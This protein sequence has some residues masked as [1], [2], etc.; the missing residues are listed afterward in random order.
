M[1]YTQAPSEKEQTFRDTRAWHG[2]GRAASGCHTPNA[3]SEPDHNRKR[4][5][6]AG[7]SGGVALSPGRRAAPEVGP[8]REAA[9]HMV[10]SW[11]GTRDRMDIGEAALDDVSPGLPASLDASLQEA[12]TGAAIS[13]YKDLA[14]FVLGGILLVFLA[15]LIAL[16]AIAIKIDSPGPVLFRQRR[17][18]RSQ[19]E[20]TIYKFRT[21]YANLSSEAGGFQATR[22]DSRVTPFGRF[23]RKTSIDEIP[24][25]INVLR[26]EMSLIGPRPHAVDHHHQYLE[27][28][29]TY[30][31]RF[32]V[33]P[34]ISG[35]AQVN[36]LRGETRQASAMEKR[37]NYDLYYIHNWSIWFDLKIMLLTVLWVRSHSRA[38][39]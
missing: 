8:G 26:G 1:R 13:R 37:V 28:I 21:M 35:W 24:Q 31:L 38:A 19:E 27:M 17:V 11:A 12:S 14:D 39:Y 15:P 29:P 6:L 20:F 4:L 23:L 34:G 25:L 30:R 16:T 2:T 9:K 3:A 32:C 5:Q 36:G 18:G 10:E 7:K 33:K 22:H